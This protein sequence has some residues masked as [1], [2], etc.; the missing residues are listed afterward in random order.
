LKPKL[1]AKT[2][3]FNTEVLPLREIRTSKIK[4]ESVQA[5]SKNNKIRTA[6]DLSSGRPEKE[7]KYLSGG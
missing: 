3:N 2:Q 4:P 7:K 1:C 6:L 5:S